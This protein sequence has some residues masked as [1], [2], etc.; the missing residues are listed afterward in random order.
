MLFF[1]SILVFINYKSVKKHS[2]E[3][4]QLILNLTLSEKRYCSLY[5]KKN[6]P[7]GQNRYLG[8]FNT[9]RQQPTYDS[10]SARLQLGLENNAGHYSVLKK[11]L[12]EQLLDALHQY[13][14]FGNPEQ[15]LMRGIHQC[16]LLM[17]KGLF[18][19]CEKR[20]NTLWQQA[21]EMCHY[22]G[23]LQ[24]QQLKMMMK[25]RKYYRHV[26]DAELEDWAAETQTL[27]AEMQVATRYRLLSSQL[28][29][30]QF[31][32]G[33]RGKELAQ[34]MQTIMDL[35]ELHSPPDDHNL[36]AKL[37]YLQMH[38]LYH[39]VNMEPVE[40]SDSNAAFLALLE[41]NPLLMQI[42][43]DRYLSTLNNYLID[44]LVLKRYE[45]LEEGLQKLRSLTDMLAFRRL[46]NIEANVF[47]LGHL[48]EMN[49]YIG[50]GRFGDAHAKI[51]E[52]QRGLDRLADKV[53]KHN[54]ITLHYLMAYVCFALAK[55][56]E[57][58]GHLWPILQEKETAVATEVQQAARMLQLLCHF[59][60]GDWMLLD[61][62]V[63]ALRRLL[64]KDETANLPRAVLSFVA[65]S[66]NKQPDH[67]PWP[68]LQKKLQK[69]AAAPTAANSMNLFNYLVWV[70]AHTQNKLFVE[71]WGG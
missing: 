41:A 52:I 3:L 30:M 21:Q 47:R 69:L 34:R 27:L 50:N 54:R 16:H 20:I 17:Q 68:D 45:L 38:A 63:K 4:H 22:E 1:M 58:L 11:Q 32:A 70:D 23:M 7:E 66:L 14:L 44:S 29:K 48:L 25:A 8:L 57:A 59:E 6:A 42:H 31:E 2:N 43:A 18:A 36:R 13:D 39:F 35:P 56:E 40:A 65:A 53:V 9:L 19:Q 62:L 71:V 67:L 51:G 24:L 37:D 28:Y 26:P 60:Q 55:Y 5:L 64:A 49:Y 15:Q 12:Y 61:S 10:D 46:T 33:G